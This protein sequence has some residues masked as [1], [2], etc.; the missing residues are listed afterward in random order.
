[1]PARA[2]RATRGLTMFPA[3]APMRRFSIPTTSGHRTISRTRSP[4]CHF[5]MQTVTGPRSRAAMTSTTISACP[6]LAEDRDRHPA[7]GEPPIVEVPESRQ[8]ML[9]NW[10]FMHLSCMVIG[11]NAVRE[12]P[13][14]SGASSGGGRR[15]VLLR[16]RARRERVVLCDERRA[17]YAAR[18]SISSTVWTAIRRSF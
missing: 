1:M 10:S 4:A 6:T 2:A 5:L 17:R 3:T 14:R 9:K 13:L 15:A 12:C 16:L 11:R 18:A 8:V 7:F